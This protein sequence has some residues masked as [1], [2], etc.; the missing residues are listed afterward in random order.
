MARSYAALYTS[1]WQDADFAA[2]TSDAQRVY[3]LAL[4]QPNI[5]YCGVVPY[6]AKR[7]A[8]LAKNTT[9]RTITKALD[10]LIAAGFV[11]LDAE[12]EELFVRSYVKHNGVLRQP[13]LVKAMEREFEQIHST[14]I[15][16]AFLAS[17]PPEY[18]GTLRSG[19][20]KADGSL[21]EACPPTDGDGDGEPSGLGLD[22]DLPITINTPLVDEALRVLA[23]READRF[24]AGQIR[25]RPGWVR[26]HIET[27]RETEGPEL[28]RLMAEYEF[29]SAVQLADALDGKKN[30]LPH[31]RRRPA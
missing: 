29:Q 16:Q 3:L 14:R 15:R 20:P 11:I 27:L 18:V 22:D 9:P 1:I 4:S 7:W 6:T 24:P 21:P 12:T 13:Q 30:V 10:E 17:L 19:C 2:L 5:S 25:S 31:L 28:R 23:E 26:A 8:R